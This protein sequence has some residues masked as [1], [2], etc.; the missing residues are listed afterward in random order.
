MKRLVFA[1]ALIVAGLFHHAAYADADPPPVECYF[2][3]E[4]LH[5]AHPGSHVVYTTHATWWIES[6]KCF[7]AGEPAA[8]PKRKPHATVNLAPSQ[9]IA[10]AT[11]QQP[12][13]PKQ[14]VQATHKQEAQPTH[15]Q[16]A[17]AT[18]KE[19]VQ[20]TPQEEGPVE[21][22]YEEN[23]A[24]LRALMFGPDESPTDFEGRFSVIG[25]K[26]TEL[27]VGH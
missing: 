22:T 16:G 7:F 4:D 9:R 15:K 12:K 23:A 11:P 18:Y 6:S 5:D 17:Q 26:G 24:A 2:S 27:T 1:I 19:E 10:K 21:G 8:R 25:N 3:P 20:A 13:Q 14:E